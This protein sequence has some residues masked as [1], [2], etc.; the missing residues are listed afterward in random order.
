MLQDLARSFAQLADPATRGWLWRSAGVALL[1][2]ALTVAGLEALLTLLAATGR[3]WLDAVVRALGALGAL[4]GAWLLFPAVLSGVLGLFLDG[5]V[6]SVERR[7]YPWLPP[8]RRQGVLE[9][10]LAG[11][12][13][14]ALGI[15]LNL[16]ALPLYLVPGLG[17][18][19][20]LALNGLLL[21]REWLEA[22]AGR[23][24]SPPEARAL[25]RAHRG[26]MWLG[27]TLVAALLLVPVLNL[28]TPVVGI[29][30]M[31]HRFHR[32]AGGAAT[33]RA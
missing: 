11:G 32:L 13:L 7:H 16:L 10:L 1:L 22:V 26:E 9:A 8:P 4:V 18:A 31:T 6:D 2:L 27:G 15:A 24:L 14:A 23:R 3:P 30:L 12:R 5:I 20:W 17:L 28:V 33:G 29:A 25:R 21:G 19:A